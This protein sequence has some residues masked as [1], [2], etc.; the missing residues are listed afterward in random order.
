M[1]GLIP[2]WSI[3]EARSTQ[4]LTVEVDVAPYEIEILDDQWSDYIKV[5]VRRYENP[6]DSIIA[7]AK[8]EDIARLLGYK[9][10]S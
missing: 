2:F 3:K 10:F 6:F 8:R 1:I 4:G 9:L 7:W 5:V